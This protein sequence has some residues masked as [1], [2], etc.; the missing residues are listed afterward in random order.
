MLYLYVRT[1][2]CIF[3]WRMKSINKCLTMQHSGDII[4]ISAESFILIIMLMG[5]DYVSELR[6][7]AGLLFI[8]R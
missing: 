5:R 3:P 8:P 2:V 4:F 1:G 7:P 6:P